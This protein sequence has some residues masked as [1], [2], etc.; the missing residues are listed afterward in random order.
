MAA[1]LCEWHWSA[2]GVDSCCLVGLSSAHVFGPRTD[3]R[4]GRETGMER[5]EAE[6]RGVEKGS[7][8]CGVL[9]V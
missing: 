1:C 7:V 8:K 5:R 4:D 6:E 9:C 2:H 3:H